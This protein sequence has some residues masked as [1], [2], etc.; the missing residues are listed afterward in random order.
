M[1]LN[2]Y[3]VISPIAYKKVETVDNG[4]QKKPTKNKVHE[5]HQ[6]TTLVLSY[7]AVGSGVHG[8][9]HAA[10]QPLA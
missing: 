5:R 7:Q 4:K 1:G 10:H 2:K 3:E 6:R 8:D 9:K